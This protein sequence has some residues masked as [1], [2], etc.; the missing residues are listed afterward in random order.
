MRFN[1][2]GE[3]V[4][5]NAAASITFCDARGSEEGAALI[6]NPLGMARLGTDDDDDSVINIHDA[7]N[8]ACNG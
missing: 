5:L 6:I 8:I 4:D 7:S 3:V 1:D 2:I